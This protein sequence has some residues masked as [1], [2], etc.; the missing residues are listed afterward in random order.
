MYRITAEIPQ[1][2]ARA[3]VDMLLVLNKVIITISTTDEDKKFPPF[4]GTLPVHT[5][6]KESQ[7]RHGKPGTRCRRLWTKG[8]SRNEK[9][10]LDGGQLERLQPSLYHWGWRHSD[11]LFFPQ[12][13][14]NKE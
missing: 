9:L 11:S 5:E 10:S 4:P 6:R 1:P 13:S 12:I 7:A 14:G 2:S 3:F 8:K